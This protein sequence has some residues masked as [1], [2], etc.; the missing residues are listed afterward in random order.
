MRGYRETQACANCKHA[1]ADSGFAFCDWFSG[2][3]WR[4]EHFPRDHSRPR[5]MLCLQDG[6]KDDLPANDPGRLAWRE[7]RMVE[8]YGLCD[9]WE[10][11]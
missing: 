4:K 3:E 1:V 8:R 9:L 10:G 6:Q 2:E 11:K 7:S 5:A